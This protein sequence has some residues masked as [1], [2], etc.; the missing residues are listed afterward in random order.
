MTQEENKELFVEAL[1]KAQNSNHFKRTGFSAVLK[2]LK[3]NKNDLGYSTDSVSHI[4]YSIGGRRIKTTLG[5]YVR[6]VLN[7]QADVIY[8][9]DLGNLAGF[10]T[11]FK[12]TTGKFNFFVV[13][14][15]GL[16]DKYS[17]NFGESSCISGKSSHL[18]K[19]YVDNPD[20]VSL[21]CFEH[22]FGEGVSGV[23]NEIRALI[24]KLDN[25]KIVCDRPYPS[26]YFAVHVIE[27]FCKRNGWF[28]TQEEKGCV[29]LKVAPGTLEMPS[30]DSFYRYVVKNNRLI[31]SN[32]NICD[33]RTFS[34]PG[35]MFE[36]KYDCDGCHRWIFESQYKTGDKYFCKNC[37]EMLSKQT[38]LI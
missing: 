22:S 21:L 18:T 12:L 17:E 34:G 28:L 31:L 3:D 20:K 2:G 35:D 38:T 13:N 5:R 30:I 24:W 33:C 19:L 7:I 15:K 16:E 11:A 26:T 36:M 32:Y 25:G 23:E 8:D 14:G 6:R 27:M 4:A 9:Y 37:F 29:T 10:F 1:E